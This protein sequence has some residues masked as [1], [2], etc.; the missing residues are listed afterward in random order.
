M[1]AKLN[2]RKY[3]KPV[4]FVWTSAFQ[5]FLYRRPLS[6]NDLHLNSNKANDIQLCAQNIY[7]SRDP[8]KMVHDHS[9]K[10]KSPK[11]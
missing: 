1:L 11:L 8:C 4:Q 2:K 10:S 9:G 3:D 6:P 5:P 7:L